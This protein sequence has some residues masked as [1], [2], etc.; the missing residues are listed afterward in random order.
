MDGGP[1]ELRWRAM[2][3]QRFSML[4]GGCG[5][6]GWGRD[7]TRPAPASASASVRASWGASRASNPPQL[8]PWW[9]TYISGGRG[10]GAIRL[11]GRVAV[12]PGT[13]QDCRTPGGIVEAACTARGPRYA[14]TQALEVD[15]TS[16]RATEWWEIEVVAKRV[17]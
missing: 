10:Q 15:L 3:P 6:V 11:Q 12:R 14:V 2:A 5:W 9:R 4:R 8:P 16:M 1:S 13:E 7:R 17:G